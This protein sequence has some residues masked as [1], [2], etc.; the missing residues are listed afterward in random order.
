MET[1]AHHVLIGL[2]TVIVAG[3]LMW[4]GLW[5]ARGG[6][7]RDADYYGLVFEEEVSGLT[8]GS[9]VLYN[10]IRVGEVVDLAIDPSDPRRTMGRIRVARDTPV[11]EDTVAQLGVTGFLTGSAHVRLSGGSPESPPLR[12]A[13]G[14]VPVID[15]EPSPFSRLRAE[16]DVLWERINTMAQRINQLLSPENTERFTRTLGHIEQTTGAIAEQTDQIRQGAQALVQAGHQADETLKEAAITLREAADTVKQASRFLEHGNHL[17][18][19]HGDD[20]FENASR[21]MVS[22]DR[23]MTRIDTLMAA[24]R[25]A[26][27]DAMQGMTEIGPVLREL[28]VTLGTLRTVVRRL[29]EDPAGFL[30]SRDTIKEFNP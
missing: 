1:R 22:L 11:S 28:R 27:D 2:F 26:M 4:F 3:G 10:G 12:R 25:D 14:E 19:S 13:E 16:G 30:M 29:E 21:S 18:D 5:L 17:L 7:E 8:V 23:T 6:L 15:V 24:N 20:I 9:S